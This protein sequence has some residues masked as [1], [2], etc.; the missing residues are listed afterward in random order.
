LSNLEDA[1]DLIDAFMSAGRARLIVV[2]QN[3]DFAGTAQIIDRRLVVGRVRKLTPPGQA[4]TYDFET[5]SE[6][7]YAVDKLFHIVKSP[8][9]PAA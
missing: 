8:F 7:L 9:I 2:M 3:S 4:N 1:S 5:W 6:M